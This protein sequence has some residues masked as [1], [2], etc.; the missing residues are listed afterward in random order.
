MG[1]DFSLVSILIPT[2]Q[3]EQFLEATLN[4]ALNQTYPNIE[5]IVSDDGSKDK[6]VEIARKFCDQSQ[7]EFKIYTNKKLGM[8]EN[9]NFC[10]S[11]AKGKYIKFLFQDDLLKSD[12]IEEMVK[13]AEKDE[14]IGLV[15]SPRSIFLSNGAD[16]LQSC[17]DIYKDCL[18]LHQAW[19]NLESIQSGQTLL[20][21]PN[22]LEYPL[23]KIGE[24]TTVL[25]RKSVLEKL[26][27]FDPKLKQ[28]VDLDMWMRIMIHYKIGFV[29]SVLSSFR[30][31]PKQQSQK[32]NTSGTT[33]KDHQL[34]YEKILI[35]PCYSLLP[36]KIKSNIYSK[37][38]NE[39]EEA[40]NRV[41]ELENR[42]KELEEELRKTQAGIFS[43][44]LP[45]INFA[46][47]I[48]TE[49]EAANS[50]IN[51][52]KSLG[53]PLKLLKPKDSKG[54]DARL[55]NPYPINLVSINT[56]LSP[57]DSFDRQMMEN[58]YN[59]GLWWSEVTEL[60]DEW[61]EQFS[62][63]EEIWV[64]SNF[65]L[66]NISKYSP[67]P[68][69]KIPPIVN[70]ELLD[71]YSKNNVYVDEH[72][73][74]FLF[75]F[76]FLSNFTRKNTLAII[77][78]F[79]KTFSSDEPV[80]LL[81]KCSNGEKDLENFAL[82]KEATNDSRIILIDD[83]L[84]QDDENELLS[85]C[86]CY[87]SLHHLEGFGLNL[88]KAM[89]LQKPVIATGW[90]GNM[91]FMNISNSYPVKYNLISIKKPQ[92]PYKQGQVWAEPDIF[93][94]AQLMRSV[95][96]NPQ[97]AKVIAK[98]AAKDIRQKYSVK[99]VAKL[100]KSRLE[101]IPESKI[102]PVGES[103]TNPEQLQLQQTYTELQ[104]A[105]AQ[106]Q[107]TQIQIRQ[108]ETKLQET[109]NWIAA[110]ESSKFWQ[111][112]RK[113]FKIKYALG[114]DQPEK[115]QKPQ[116]LQKI[117]EIEPP[118]IVNDI[119]HSVQ[120]S[121]DSASL[122][123]N[124]GFYI[125]GWI[126]DPK[127]E[128]K[129]LTLASED[130]KVDLRRFIQKKS[131]KDVSDYFQKQGWADISEDLGFF[132]ICPFEKTSTIQKLNLLV[133]LES[134]NI[135]DYKIEFQKLAEDPLTI[136]QHILTNCPLP[137]YR[138]GS[139]LN[140]YV[141]PTIKKIWENREK[142]EITKVVRSYGTQNSTP[143][144]SLIVPLYGRIDFI[145]YQLALFAD[146]PDFKENELIYVLDDPRLYDE[147]L[148]SCDAGSSIFEV[149]FKT[150]YSGRNLGYAGANNLGVSISSGRL[151]LLLNSDV[152][153]IRSLWLLSLVNVYKS[154]PNVGVIAP[155]LLYGDGSIQHAGLKF[156]K[157][158]SRGDFWVNEHP[159][160]GQPN[161]PELT[162]A[163][164]K[165]AAVTGACMMVSRQLY[166]LVGGLDEEYI[167]GDYEDSD[168]CL[169]LHAQGR[170][171]YYIP[172]IE[173]Y[174][175]ERQSL[176]QHQNE[177]WRLNR[178]LYNCWLYNQKW[179]KYI[180]E[181]NL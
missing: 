168:F 37:A 90:S 47:F 79:E 50:Y 176:S 174:H 33:L 62:Y 113:W 97:E 3:G 157:S 28:I 99:T 150:V 65:A 169:K 154:L 64:A 105:Q 86:D 170:E 106:L 87:I 91:D 14:E 117:V 144:V 149:P 18:D 9:W 8:V 73:F 165:L 93:H 7:N 129:E 56:D 40:K 104:K 172:N 42:E 138:M 173:L 54:S 89:F 110:M 75:I 26:G 66:E 19:S 131:R 69:V 162:Y 2:Y 96:E 153:P 46:S 17:L 137:A 85:L 123:P 102:L 34:F 103:Q 121:I 13:L 163:P 44:Q 179:S 77:E 11:V 55:D 115:H 12:C 124:V 151:I 74:V 80:R 76:D 35:D 158:A 114:L 101:T 141:G 133:K 1:K 71:A 135:L 29:N 27:G 146:D 30:I 45:G 148:Y 38:T 81:I 70:I 142:P 41:K 21:D 120:F 140:E 22:F 60:S 15:F 111:L 127:K 53:V 43:L 167:I 32:N 109:E 72:E 159:R 171:N 6:T 52:I 125:T 128:I 5:I 88:A 166:D 119:P 51:V 108:T 39:L 118:A 160:K 25:I 31:H 107:Q 83:Y 61:Y 82:L 155:K 78:A 181:K 84:S 16:S 92:A 20:A 94:A 63:F 112:R 175:L 143:E 68:V 122:M 156:I 59:I 126:F 36:Q 161:F 23:N 152:M 49:C 134:G 147:F 67:I 100:I 136:I 4:S 10:I 164:Q 116:A 58:K 139:V 177:L 180:T 130:E 24:P 145:K 48:K 178:T 57:S 98:R 95:Y 132:G